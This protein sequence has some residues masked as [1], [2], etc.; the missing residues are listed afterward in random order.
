MKNPNDPRPVARVVNTSK[1][2]I[3]FI[4]VLALFA[5][6]IG[7]FIEITLAVALVACGIACFIT[8]GLV[9]GLSYMTQAA[10]LYIEKC[11][12]EWEASNAQEQAEAPEE[13]EIQ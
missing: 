4:G 3:I 8:G 13:S 11:T 9:A 10:E 12:E 2:F 7:F 5:G 1:K 6:V